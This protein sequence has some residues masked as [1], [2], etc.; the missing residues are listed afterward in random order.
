M[1]NEIDNLVDQLVE[2]HQGV[3][4]EPNPLV[5]IAPLLV[6]VVGY[7]ASVVMLI[8]LRSDWQAMITGPVTYQ[9]ELL[10]SLCVGVSG[11]L[12][13]GWLRIPYTINQRLIVSSALLCGVAFI[14][15]ELFRLVSE[16]V[17]L[18][19][20]SSFISCYQHSLY[21]ATLPTIALVMTQRS[22]STT[23]PYLSALMGV[24]AIAGFAWIGLRLTCE[25]NLAGHNAIVQLSPFI[26]LGMAMGLGAKKIYRW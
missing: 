6:G 24:F 2:A 4:P 12:A 3:E 17:S 20:V 1:S 9:V 15:F 22:G 13:T 10:L 16:G 25:V 11:M 18:A 8:G 26:L 5:K 14:G 19:S 21:L 23:H 7:M